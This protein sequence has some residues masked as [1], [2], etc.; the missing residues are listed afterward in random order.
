MNVTQVMAYSNLSIHKKNYNVH[1]LLRIH[2]S[3][4]VFKNAES[5][6]KNLIAFFIIWLEFLISMHAIQK[7]IAFTSIM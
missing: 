5:R 4:P 3:M 7:C 1:R 6:T 2:K